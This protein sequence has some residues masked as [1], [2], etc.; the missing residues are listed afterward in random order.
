MVEPNCNTNE[1][2]KDIRTSG[3]LAFKGLEAT[4]N[5]LQEQVDV[6]KLRSELEGVFTRCKIFFKWCRL[7]NI[8]LKVPQNGDDE[9]HT[10]FVSNFML[11]ASKHRSIAPKQRMMLLV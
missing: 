10:A 6:I 5:R 11:P 4:C 9:T 3:I 1:D 8:S 7:W 2:G